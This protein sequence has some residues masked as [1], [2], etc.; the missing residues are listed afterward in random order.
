MCSSISTETTRSNRRRISKAAMSAVTTSTL[1]RPRRAASARMKSRWLE[2]FDTA[3]M[4]LRG[5]RSAAQRVS[6]PQ[7]QPSSSTRWPSARPARSPVRR[8]IASSAS[9]RFVAPSGQSA[10]EYLRRRP[11]TSR[12]KAAGLVVLLVGRPRLE[13][14]GAAAQ[15]LDPGREPR[16]LCLDAASRLLPRPLGHEPA[17]AEPEDEVGQ[18]TRLDEGV[19]AVSGGRGRGRCRRAHAAFSWRQG[20]VSGGSLGGRWRARRDS[21]PQPSASK[22]DALSG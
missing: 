11:R 14:D 5:K 15:R 4:R 18:E 1:P 7:P 3:V 22:A 16:L 9:S 20:P 13:R 2:E 19:Q 8:S 21:N 12:K 17:D 6:D 10:Q